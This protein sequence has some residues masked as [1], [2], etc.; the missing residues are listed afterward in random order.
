MCD[1]HSSL[2]KEVSA[3]KTLLTF[4][5]L[6]IA[7]PL[8]IVGAAS[9]DDI[10][11]PE[12]WAGIWETTSIEIDCETLVAKPATVSLDTLC[13]GDI[14]NPED[15]DGIF[16]CTGSITGD[17]VHMECSGTV[18]VMP[19]CSLTI[20]FESDGT[21]NGETNSGVT[22]NRFTYV[23]AAC[24]FEDTCTRTEST[25]IRVGFDTSCVTPVSSE[26]WGSLKSVYR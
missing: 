22:I 12:N 11:V 16:N 18:E 14:M 1:D 3:M 23:G 25:S 15:P 26:T 9:A 7:A 20:S 17:T 5:F 19:G 2:Q 13:A 10:I 4:T 24:F 21:M 6:L 8:L